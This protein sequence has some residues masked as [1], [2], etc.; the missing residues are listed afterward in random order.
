MQPTNAVPLG[1]PYPS[2]RPGLARQGLDVYRANGCASCHSQ[3]VRQT[4]TVCDVVLTDPGTNRAALKVALQKLNLDAN[5]G[6]LPKTLLRGVEKERADHAIADL[7]TA[8][9]K[10]ELWVVPVG[11]DITQ[12]WGKR[13]SVAEDFLYDS[14]VMLARNASV[15]TWRTSACASRI[16]IGTCVICSSRRTK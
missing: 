12:G 11:P 2:A 8:S 16:S 4:D 3:Q 15:R 1:T 5:L 9:A 13:R 6:A 7:K 10:V 14:P